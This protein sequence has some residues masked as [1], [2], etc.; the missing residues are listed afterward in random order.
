MITDRREPQIFGNQ[1]LI[2]SNDGV[3]GRF[4]SRR[5]DRSEQCYNSEKDRE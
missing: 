2:G 5:G 3:F 4:F 1:V